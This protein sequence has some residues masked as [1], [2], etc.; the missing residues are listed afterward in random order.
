MDKYN[1]QSNETV[2]IKNDQVYHNDTN[3]DLIL[4]NLF[5][6]FI[7]T[8]GMF[9]TKYITQ[10]YP[11]NQIKVFNGH[12]QIIAGKNGEI[13][14]YFVN[15]QE[16]F[17]FWNN[18]NFFS[19]KKAEKEAARWVNAINQLITGQVVDTSVTSANVIPGTE[20]LAE[21]LKGTYDTFKGTFGIKSKTQ[22]SK[23]PE[24]VACKCTS[25]GAPISGI[26]AQVVRC[27]YCDSE[28]QL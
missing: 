16:H 10:R 20:F 7:S 2:L 6:V 12:A 13:D 25:C 21:T 3:G 19:D 17:R 8:K 14:I 15:S 26:K 28:Q 24:K 1:L 22:D 5:L 9:T 18:E 27:Q 23:L 11:I 4:T